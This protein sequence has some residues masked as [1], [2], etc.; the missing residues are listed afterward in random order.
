MLRNLL[1]NIMD[2]SIEIFLIV[3]AVVICLA[4]LVVVMV[5]ISSKQSQKRQAEENKQEQTVKEEKAKQGELYLTA[6]E[7]EALKY[8]VQSNPIEGKC[9]PVCGT[10]LTTVYRDAV[11]KVDYREK[12]EGLYKVVGNTAYDVYQDAVYDKHY[13]KPYHSCPKCRYI[14]HYELLK[15]QSVTKTYTD[16]DGDEFEKRVGSRDI[17]ELELNWGDLASLMYDVVIPCRVKEIDI[18]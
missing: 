1:A 18:R 8:L 2:K 17:A 15:N 16:S 7:K 6:K 10:E 13:Q 5:L 3:V 4:V 9:C 14:W 12:V 11:N